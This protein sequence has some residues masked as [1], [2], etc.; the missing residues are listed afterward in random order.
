MFAK[1]KGIN[2]VLYSALFA[3][4]MLSFFR[5]IILIYCNEEDANNN[6]L[7]VLTQGVR[8]DLAT[9]T[10]LYG[11][12]ALLLIIFNILIIRRKRLPRVFIKTIKILLGVSFAF[13]VLNEIATF[14]F[15]DEYSVRP[16]YIYVEFLKNPEDLFLNI[17]KDHTISFLISILFIALSYYGAYRFASF[18]FKG[19]RKFDS[20]Y[21]SLSV[22]TLVLIISPL[23]VRSTFGHRPFNPAMIAYSKSV[24]ANS[25]PLNSTYS[26]A[27]ALTHKEEK[28]TNSNYDLATYEEIQDALHTFSPS[29]VIDN[30]DPKCTFNAF[31]TP[32]NKGKKKNVIIVLEESFGANFVEKLEGIPLAPN[33]K[34][35]AKDAWFFKNMYATGHRSIHGIESLT[36]GLPPSP[37]L[38]IVKTQKTAKNVA[39]LFNIYK[40]MGY[41][42][43][44]IYGGE[45]EFDNMRNY[46]IDNSAETIIDERDYKD[47]KVVDSLGVSDEELFMHAHAEFEKEYKSNNK[48]FSLI[49]TSSLKNHFDIPE[50]IVELPKDNSLNKD[51]EA[52]FKS[53]MYADYA[54]GKFIDKVR[55]SDYYKD[56]IIL[57]IADHESHINNTKSPFPIY[58]FRVPAMILGANVK[59]YE[60][61][62]L[63]SQI[64]MTPTLLSL[65][66]IKGSFPYIGEDLNYDIDKKYVAMQYN[67]TFALRN[68]DN[69][70]I[71]APQKEAV[72]V[73][74]ID[75][76][77]ELKISEEQSSLL[78]LGIGIVNLGPYL[79][80]N[81]QIH[82]DCIKS[83]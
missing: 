81:G 45:S 3:V 6:I 55:N 50:G 75:D 69:A 58:D 8:V 18:L 21:T 31:I 65:S 42:T 30:R 66:G 24:L 38:S 44:F 72:F 46:F 52:R 83:K 76:K 67:D 16:N 40:K 2:P 28:T 77:E 34:R 71:L 61:M 9:I 62:R 73:Q 27:Y 68:K 59:A 57:I 19:Y 78:E 5:V 51:Q 82:V 35:I 48:F 12:I 63:T 11:V 39:T 60:D 47:P 13:L 4:L 1:N 43:S 22:L 17:I 32:I 54:L 14:N 37:I 41:R 80:Q 53:L 29:R 64:D 20:L 23:L 26:V 70:V 49:F 79:Y 25:I 74:T 33:F 56:T 36:A 7:Y 10:P 15:I